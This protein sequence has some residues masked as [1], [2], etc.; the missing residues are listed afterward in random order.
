M[1]CPIEVDAPLGY[2]FI[3]DAWFSDPIKGKR[4]A[5]HLFNNMQSPSN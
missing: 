3:A 1:V 5:E 4:Y 2:N